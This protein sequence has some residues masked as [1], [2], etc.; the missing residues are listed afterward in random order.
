MSLIAR[1][2]EIGDA[3]HDRRAN[4]NVYQEK[5]HLH[6]EVLSKRE[7]SN[8]TFYSSRHA[9]DFK[10]NNVSLGFFLQ[11]LTQDLSH[12]ESAWPAT[13]RKESV[14]SFNKGET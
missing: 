9:H 7:E 1:E 10:S 13:R 11:H 3:N 4:R 8:I 12:G 2:D 5:F 14:I 6:S